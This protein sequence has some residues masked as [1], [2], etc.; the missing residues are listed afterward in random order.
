MIEIIN[1]LILR[2]FF[3]HKFNKFKIKID[4]L[5]LHQVKANFRLD[6]EVK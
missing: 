2:W 5:C 6:Q 1:S 3:Y 4:K